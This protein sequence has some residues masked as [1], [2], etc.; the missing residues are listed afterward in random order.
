MNTFSFLNL[1]EEDNLCTKDTTAEFKLVPKRPLFK[2]FTV[3]AFKTVVKLLASCTAVDI[4]IHACY[5]LV[6]RYTVVWIVAASW[7]AGSKKYS[8]PNKEST[9]C[10]LAQT[11]V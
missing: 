8:A 9:F 6:S 1:Q 11:C 7:G 5:C 3:C 4:T 10:F 2:D